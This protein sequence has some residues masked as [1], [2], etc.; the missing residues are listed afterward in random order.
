MSQEHPCP[1]C[2]SRHTG[3]CLLCDD[4]ELLA[5]RSRERWGVPL[6]PQTTLLTREEPDD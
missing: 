1:W 3:T 6:R 4:H 5:Q 2:L